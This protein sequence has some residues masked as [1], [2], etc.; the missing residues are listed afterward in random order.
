MQQRE[1]LD[2]FEKFVFTSFVFT[3]ANMFIFWTM[4][5]TQNTRRPV[6]LEQ[7]EGLDWFVFI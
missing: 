3:F 2:W 5:V 1:G 6:C 7:R 4:L